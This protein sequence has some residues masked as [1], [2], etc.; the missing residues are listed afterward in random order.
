MILLDEPIGTWISIAA[1]LISLSTLILSFRKQSHDER[2]ALAKSIAE[3]KAIYGENLTLIDA[4][5]AY[6]KKIIDFL[7]DA[8]QSN[9]IR[10]IGLRLKEAQ[11]ILNNVRARVNSLYSSLGH[12]EPLTKDPLALSA[13]AVESADT[14][15]F[16]Q[17]RKS[18]EA[19]LLPEIK[20]IV[21]K[22]RQS[23]K[24]HKRTKRV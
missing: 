21:T 8:P 5:L 11:I 22:L 4:I 3:I 18:E 10:E 9:Q 23:T 1:F 2:T 19:E 7:D 16:L 14:R 12:Q 13:I 24:G 6:D 20:I 15:R 17:Q